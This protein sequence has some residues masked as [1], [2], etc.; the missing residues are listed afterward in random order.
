MWTNFVHK[1]EHD[2]EKFFGGSQNKTQSNETSP[3]FATR[4]QCVQAMKSVG[5]PCRTDAFVIFCQSKK[6][7]PDDAEVSYKLFKCFATNYYSHNQYCQVDNH[8]LQKTDPCY[9]E[10]V[11]WQKAMNHPPKNQK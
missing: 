6:Y 8:K 10:F 7:V 5:S 9:N 4:Q 11:D 2:F 3:S 1:V